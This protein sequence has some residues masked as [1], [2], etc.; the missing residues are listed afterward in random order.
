MLWQANLIEVHLR[1]GL[2]LL[3]VGHWHRA[4]DISKHQDIME[5]VEMWNRDRIGPKCYLTVSDSG[6]VHLNCEYILP[7]H[8]GLTD[9]QLAQFLNTGVNLMLAVF[10][11]AEER[12]P[13]TLAQGE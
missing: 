12:F 8:L 7:I 6:R 9:P 1:K 11:A 10:E 2:P 5:F 4:G 13:D 3:M